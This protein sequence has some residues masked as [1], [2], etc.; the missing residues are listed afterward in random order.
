VGSAY[1]M[2]KEKRCDV[3]KMLGGEG[4]PSDSPIFAQ[5]VPLRRKSG[6]ETLQDRGA[7]LETEEGNQ[8]RVSSNSGLAK[9][10][11]L[12]PSQVKKNAAGQESKFPPGDKP[13]R[14]TG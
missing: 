5:R 12:R 4:F 8:K 14:G 9:G 1:V 10:K 13:L 6:R 2:V 11:N 3:R 7:G